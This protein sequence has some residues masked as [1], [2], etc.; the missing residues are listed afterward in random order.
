MTTLND[1]IGSHWTGE[2]ELWL[3]P[4]GNE[5]LRCPSTI[6]IE[7]G[8]VRYTWSYEG[9]PQQGTL[10]LRDG[11]LDYTDTFHQPTPL[12]FTDVPG[13]WGM[14]NV[15]GTYAAGGG[16]DWGWRIYL[17]LRSMG[18]PNLVLQMT[19][20]APWGE[21]GRAVRMICVRDAD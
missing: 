16:P 18:D 14:I 13:G 7:A 20:I 4:L 9:E 19:N 8:A 3:D 15:A 5:V 21:E 17:G 6:A 11:G 12:G 1:L 2:N 10:Q